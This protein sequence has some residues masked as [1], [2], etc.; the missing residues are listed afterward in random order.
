MGL[1]KY[2]EGDFEKYKTWML[3]C[4]RDYPQSKA[5]DRFF[6]YS[7]Y[8][9]ARRL[10]KKRDAIKVVFLLNEIGAWKT[11]GLYLAMCRH[12]RFAPQLI[13][14]ASEEVKN[15]DL[16]MIDF[17]K[18]KGYDY[19]FIPQGMS[20]DDYDIHPDI[21]FYEKPYITSIHAS[22]HPKSLLGP[23]YCY[24]GYAFHNTD[25]A[26][27]FNQP[28]TNI[29][30]KVFYEHK[31]MKRLANAYMDNKWNGCATGIPMMDSLR[32]SPDK[33]PDPWKAQSF[34]KKRIIWAPHHTLG[35]EGLMAETPLA[36]FLDYA[37]E[38]LRLAKKYEKSV[39]WAFKPHPLLYDKLV[40]LWGEQR[41]RQ[42]YNQWKDMANTQLEEG[43][44]V[45]LFKHSDAMIHDCGSFMVEYHYTLNPVMYLVR[46]D[47]DYTKGLTEMTK[48]GFLLHVIGHNKNDIEQF[49]RNVISGKDMGRKSRQKFYRKYLIPKGKTACDNIMYRILT[50]TRK[51]RIQYYCME[52]FMYIYRRR[53]RATGQL[54]PHDIL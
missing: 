47:R 23:L 25:A 44:Y 14:I 49:V 8:T 15:A 1:R 31:E 29:C 22:Y 18:N 34:S 13:A 37:D 7:V 5:A 46:G 48:Q 11:E 27:N 24:T 20:L 54:E 42:Y 9:R 36:T 6:W 52:L 19:T 2:F 53:L 3:C 10:Q 4:S 40:K 12:P 41:T 28:L 39:Q 50:M 45:G 33:V 17:L 51:E 35:N 21:V 16:Q 26:W 30:W 32:I 38:M 43:E